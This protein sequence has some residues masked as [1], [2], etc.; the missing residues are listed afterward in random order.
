MA[1]QKKAK[2]SEIKIS[3]YIEEVEM[4]NG[5]IGVVINDGDDDFIVVLDKVGKELRN[6]LEEEVEVIG[7]V[8]RKGSELRLKVLDY[9]LFDDYVDDT[10]YTYL[11][12]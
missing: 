6:H 3:G 10:A 12:D 2:T 9:R 11:E 1:S 8:T 4:E 7:T 5:D